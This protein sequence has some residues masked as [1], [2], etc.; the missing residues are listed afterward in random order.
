MSR[1]INMYMGNTMPGFI[2][3]DCFMALMGPLMEKLRG[4]VEDLIE[5]VFQIIKNTGL[6]Y[7]GEIFSSKEV[8]RE[9]L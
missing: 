1:I 8:I 2:S 9:S 7:I 4:P 6:F 3:V 5:Q